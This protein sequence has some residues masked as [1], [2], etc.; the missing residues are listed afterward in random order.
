MGYQSDHKV[1]EWKQS[2]PRITDQHVL[3][4]GITF[5]MTWLEQE[6]A[7]SIADGRLLR[8]IKSVLDGA[9]VWFAYVYSNDIGYVDRL[10]LYI[11]DPERKVFYLLCF[12]I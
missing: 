10:A 3:M 5:A 7:C 2:P 8:S 9:G 12:G 4:E 11:L 1:V 6:H